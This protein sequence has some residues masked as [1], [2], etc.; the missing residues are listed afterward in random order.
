MAC[1]SNAVYSSLVQAAQPCLRTAPVLGFVFV[2]V[3]SCEPSVLSVV[4]A[5]EVVMM[6]ADML[7]AGLC[8]GPDLMCT[9][10]LTY[11]VSGQS[12]G[13]VSHSMGTQIHS[14]LPTYIAVDLWSHVSA[15]HRYES[16]NRPHC[17][18]A[19]LQLFERSKETMGAMKE[20]EPKARQEMQTALAATPHCTVH[21]RGPEQLY[22]NAETDKP[23]KQYPTKLHTSK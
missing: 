20:V 17:C 15:R 4:L 21:T 13:E 23:S 7:L 5:A 8:Q 1:S 3:L 6:T 22:R 18:N 2:P 14:R 19:C 9:V 10:T 12:D 11:H 16:S